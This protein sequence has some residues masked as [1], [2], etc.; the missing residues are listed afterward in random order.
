MAGDDEVDRQF[1]AIVSGADLARLRALTGGW[2]DD[3]R[4]VGPRPDLRRARLSDAVMFRIRVDLND[5]EP[6][7]WRVLDLRSDLTLDIVHSL[8][9]GAFSW[10]NSHLHRF[11]LGGG[12]FDA[13]SQLF[14]C[15]FDVEEGEDEG[16]PA[17][18]VRL[19]ETLQD[20]GDVLRYVYDYGDSWELTLRLEQVREIRHD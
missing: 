7:I 6:A 8:L 17:E 1:A 2:V 15:P 18:A 12:P 11:A 9:Q 19:D 14:L 10:T 5:S 3:P 16:M 13:D 20:V 4:L